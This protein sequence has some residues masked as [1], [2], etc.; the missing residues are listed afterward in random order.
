MVTSQYLERIQSVELALSDRWQFSVA[1]SEVSVAG[2]R[3]AREGEHDFIIPGVNKREGLRGEFGIVLE[4]V[5][6]MVR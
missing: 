4:P 5:Q 3:V 1:L 6:S 2:K